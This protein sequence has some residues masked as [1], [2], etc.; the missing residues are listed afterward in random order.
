MGVHMNFELI[1]PPEEIREQNAAELVEEGI[2]REIIGQ[3]E[4]AG[5]APEQT[6]AIVGDLEDV[7]NWHPQAESMSCA[8]SVQELIAEQLLDKEISEAA[9]IDFAEWAGWYDPVEGTAMDNTG[10]VLEVMGLE[11]E[12]TYGTTV[13]DL[14]QALAEGEKII[15]AVDNMSLVDPRFAGI[16]GRKANHAV[17]LV[18]IDFSDP[19]N[20]QVILNDT[21]V[22]NGQGIRH[23]LDVFMAAWKTSGNFAA[24]AGK[25]D[26]A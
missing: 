15:C 13:S 19:E 2:L 17:Q 14:L 7:E 3:T 6:E 10:N 9:V 4:L 20:P 18:A 24:F 12:R 5:M 21:G 1:N 8:V 11:V 25:G 23:D 26:A 16:P 22:E